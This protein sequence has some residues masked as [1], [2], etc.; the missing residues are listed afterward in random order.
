[1]LRGSTLWVIDGPPDGPTRDERGP[2]PGLAD[3]GSGA[4]AQRRLSSRPERR[5]PVVGGS[6][7]DGVGAV[8]IFRMARL[9]RKPGC[10]MF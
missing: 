2:R 10:P 9:I 7:G 5:G 4:A 6:L 8:T 3:L 1:M